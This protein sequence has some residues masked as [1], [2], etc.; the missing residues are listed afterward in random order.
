MTTP[1]PVASGRSTE[2]PTDSGFPVT[3][4]GTAWPTCIEYVS[5]IQA[6][7]CSSVAMSGAGMSRWGPMIGRSS[8]VN[9]RVR[10]SRS[11]GES[12]RGTHRTPPFAPP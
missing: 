12:S 4:S 6:I 8:E 5:I 9:R 10:R 11:P 7:V 3:I 1:I 2:P